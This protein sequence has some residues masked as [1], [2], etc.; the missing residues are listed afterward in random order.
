[1]K[2]GHVARPSRNERGPSF[3]RRDLAIELDG[4]ILRVARSLQQPQRIHDRIAQR[5][6]V[7]IRRPRPTVRPLL[8][9]GFM[10]WIRLSETP[11]YFAML[12]RLSPDRMA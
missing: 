4:R 6:G 8:T 11:K 7:G 5:V 2:N 9:H 12:N 3:G 1:M 10:V